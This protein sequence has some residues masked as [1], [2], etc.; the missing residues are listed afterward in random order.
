MPGDHAWLSLIWLLFCVALIIGLAYWFTKHV[1]GGGALRG[2]GLLGG[3]NSGEQVKVLARLNLGREQALLLVR[4]GERH[5]LLGVTP[6]SISTLAEF[7]QEEAQAWPST[8]ESP[9]SPSFS[10]A[11]RT[12]LQQKK[13]R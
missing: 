8:P 12:V 7:T 13:Q 3:A 1:V 11:L 4:V 10:E 5:F 2:S 9:A 6:S